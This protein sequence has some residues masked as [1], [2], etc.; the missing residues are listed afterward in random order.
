MRYEALM[1]GHVSLVGGLQ[2]RLQQFRYGG[3][4]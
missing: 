1:R 3:V 4:A 2:P